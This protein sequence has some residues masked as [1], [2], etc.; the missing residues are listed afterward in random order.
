MT[1]LLGQESPGK[2][3]LAAMETHPLAMPAVAVVEP[4]V[5]DKLDSQPL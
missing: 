3:F 5:K 2:V 1:K 4:G